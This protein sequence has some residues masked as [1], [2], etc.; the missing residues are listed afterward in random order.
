MLTSTIEEYPLS[1]TRKGNQITPWE[2][3]SDD[4]VVIIPAFGTTLEIEEYLKKRNIE[5]STYNTTCPF[6]E[7]VWKMAG[8]LG[9][10]DFTIIIHG[11]FKHEETQATFSHSR[12]GVSLDR[13]PKH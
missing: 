9:K 4:A 2:N 10:N 11:K 1:W 7:K 8:K 13:D 6:V 12:A 3:V 5:T